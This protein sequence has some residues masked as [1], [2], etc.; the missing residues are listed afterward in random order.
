MHPWPLLFYF[1]WYLV[2]WVK[3]DYSEQTRNWC[4]IK[5]HHNWHY[6]H[7]R[8][9][10]LLTDAPCRYPDCQAA[11][12]NNNGTLAYPH[13]KESFNTLFSF[14]NA[15]TGNAYVGFSMPIYF[16]PGPHSGCTGTECNEKLLTSDNQQFNYSQWMNHQFDRAPNQPSCYMIHQNET[17]VVPAKCDEPLMAIC[18]S[19]CPRPG[20]PI[21][22]PP[23]E[24]QQ[25]TP[26][27]N[28]LMKLGSLRQKRD[29]DSIQSNPTSDEFLQTPV[30]NTA[31]L[32]ALPAF[33][34]DPNYGAPATATDHDLVGYDCSIPR[35]LTTVQMLNSEDPCGYTPQPRAQRNESFLLLQKAER[36]PTMVT[37]C[38]I[39]ETYIPYY[40]GVWS[41]TVLQ[42]K[43]MKFEEPVTITQEECEKLWVDKSWTDDSGVTHIL[44][45]NSTY[46]AYFNRAG[47]T[48]SYSSGPSCEGGQYKV[49]DTTYEKMVVTVMRS[50][51]L[52]QY[53]A[54]VDDNDI[55][56]IPQLAITLPCGFP[57]LQCKTHQHGTF[58]WPAKTR[59]DMCPYFQTRSTVGIVIED[60]QNRELYI[61]TDNSMLRLLIKDPISRCG[62]IIY[63]TNY[64]RLFLT[65]TQ[66]FN[67]FPDKLPISEMSIWTYAN[68]QDDY[69]M[70][71]LTRFI[72][73]EFTAVHQHSCKSSIA[74]DRFNYDR[75]L[76][77][78]HGSTDGDTAALGGGYFLTVA[79][80]AYY[81]YRCRRVIVRARATN[82]CYSSLPVDLQ[83]DDLVRYMQDRQLNTS[84]TSLEFF[85]EPHSRHLS[86]RAVKLPC[87]DTF[88]PLYASAKN[89]WIR[90]DPIITVTEN[91]EPLNLKTF[92]DLPL[93][94]A[95]DWD[96][97]AGGIYTSDQIHQHDDHLGIA[98]AVKDVQYTMGIKAQTT[99]WSS[100]RSSAGFSF[101]PD[102][103]IANIL[104]FN[105]WR[106]GWYLLCEWGR[107][108]SIVLGVYYLFYILYWLFACGKAFMFPVESPTS[109]LNRLT[110]AVRKPQFPHRR[111]R[112]RRSPR[113]YV[114]YE[115]ISQ[116]T[117]NTPTFPLRRIRS[118]TS[119]RYQSTPGTARIARN[120][121]R[122]PMEPKPTTPGTMKRQQ[123]YTRPRPFAMASMPEP[124]L[125]DTSTYLRTGSPS[126]PRTLFTNQPT[127]TN[128][129]QPQPTYPSVPNAPDYEDMRRNT[130]TVTNV[131][132]A[133]PGTSTLSR[134]FNRL[135][136]GGSYNVAAAAAAAGLGHIRV[137]PHIRDT[138][139][140]V[141]A[142]MDTMLQHLNELSGAQPNLQS[143]CNNILNQV[144]GLKTRVLSQ[145]LT[146]E[147]LLSVSAQL[148]AH[149][150]KLNQMTPA[151][152]IY[153]QS[154]Q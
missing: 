105:I 154:T 17:A 16:I 37:S 42:P 146:P 110:S 11:C 21:L 99:G 83:R 141:L 67:D 107:L 65:S 61:S 57:Q 8:Y 12:A 48:Y 32:D 138:K 86:T 46:K 129:Q 137:P 9:Y 38:K 23:L 74:R 30:T 130:A 92:S 64:E 98:T 62:H 75:I 112:R 90:V 76:A 115:R 43:W 5:P 71:T 131:T 124:R 68:M 111:R 77:E 56:H 80:E 119:V 135:Q 102:Q 25:Q 126:P 97:E 22:P 104:S 114:H 3:T 139:R 84:A 59:K 79:G 70:G 41:H 63:R 45:H 66:A 49:G 72:Q 27:I 123:Y 147:Q 53:P 85:L 96:F 128:L 81:R 153:G 93:H 100:S 33:P 1:F 134:S 20:A 95:D 88:A 108:C 2:P 52:Y 78:Q 140:Q 120:K 13:S 91:P 24:L 6:Q 113:E 44:A 39:Q 152:S 132:Q 54:T 47:K 4:D 14:V 31:M 26:L 150:Q 51:E 144:V 145:G 60:S 148:N 15:F 19:T 89:S 28:Q 34:T 55:I 118:D 29:A 143:S 133:V 125:G 58:Y 82:E 151:G 35:E 142:Q 101:A 116:S 87:S 121:S 50:I 136:Q 36:T 106:F 122:S 73:Q 7:D 18:E 10:T 117:N 103:I 109:A 127:G 40:C 69:M 149:Q 94:D